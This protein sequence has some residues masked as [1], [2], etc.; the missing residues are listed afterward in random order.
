MTMKFNRTGATKLPRFQFRLR[1]LMIGVTLVGVWM[2]LLMKAAE[3]VHEAREAARRVPCPNILSAP[4]GARFI[5][6]A[7]PGSLAPA[8]R[9]PG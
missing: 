2:P 7:A 5:P 9:D 4:G 6:M 8:A 3:A 1:T